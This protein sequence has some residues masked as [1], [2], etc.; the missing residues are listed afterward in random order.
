METILLPHRDLSAAEVY[1][2][3]AGSQG[4]A[5]LCTAQ[6]LLVQDEAVSQPLVATRG[7]LVGIS[8][9]VGLWALV[10][11]AILNSAK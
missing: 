5:D 4:T 9:S 1:A 6:Q 8:L 10:I 3:P 2:Q 11:L 7:V